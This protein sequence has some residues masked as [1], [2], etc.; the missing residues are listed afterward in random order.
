MYTIATSNTASLGTG[1]KMAVAG[2]GKMAAKGVK[3]IQLIFNLLDLEKGQ[4]Y[5]VG[6]GWRGSIWVFL[7]V[8]NRRNVIHRIIQ[9]ALKRVYFMYDSLFI[10][11]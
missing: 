3:N 10:E 8:C 5:G 6:G 9:T 4:Q 2:I 11:V 7:F 1:E